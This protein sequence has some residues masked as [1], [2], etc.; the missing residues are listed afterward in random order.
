MRRPAGGA[1]D[2]APFVGSSLVLRLEDGRALGITLAD[3][4]GRVLAEGH[5]P[6]RCLCC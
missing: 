3:G 4:A 1:F 6:S 5:G 2:F